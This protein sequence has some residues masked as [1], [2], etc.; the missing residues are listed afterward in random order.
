MNSV[1]TTK[2]LKIGKESPGHFFLTL[3]IT[4]TVSMFF[5]IFPYDALPCISRSHWHGLSYHY[6]SKINCQNISYFDRTK[7]DTVI[8]RVKA[9]VQWQKSGVP[10]IRNAGLNPFPG[11]SK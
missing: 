5:L 4:L 7:V 1:R 10:S 11:T 2:K 9:F 3:P 8:Y 6:S